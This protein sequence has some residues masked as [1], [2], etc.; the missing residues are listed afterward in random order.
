[1]K[2]CYWVVIH[3]FVSVSVSVCVYVQMLMC[4][5]ADECVCACVYTYVCTC[6]HMYVNVCAYTYLCACVWCTYRWLDLQCW[7]STKGP[8]V[9]PL[10]LT[11]GSVQPHRP[12][13]CLVVQEGVLGV[14]GGVWEGVQEGLLVVGYEWLQL[15]RMEGVCEK[16]EDGC[17]RAR[18][19]RAVQCRAGQDRAGQGG[20]RW[21][22]VDYVRIAQER[23]ENRRGG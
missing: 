3:D 14:I 8:A 18:S 21:G 12:W 9:S 11:S 2:E 15:V 6:V 4:L 16:C 7:G 17:S 19:G 23:N 5:C 22:R 13:V 20:A 1:M 10:M